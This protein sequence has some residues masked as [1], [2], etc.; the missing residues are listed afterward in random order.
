VSVWGFDA[1]GARAVGLLAACRLLPGAIAL[2]FGAWAADR[3]P[4]RRVAV[5]VFS[6]EAAALLGVAAAMMVDAPVGIVAVIVGS[7]SVALTPYRPAHLA[8]IP[9]AAR[10][11]EQLVAANVAS[12]AIEGVAT[13]TGPLLAALLLLAADPWVPTLAA[14]GAA[15]LGVLAVSG[16]HVISDPSRAM[17]QQRVGALDA[18]AR[19]FQVLWRDRDQALIVGCFVMQLLVRGLLSVMI[20]LVAL[21][22]FELGDSGVGWLSAAVGAGAVIGAAVAVGLT[23]RRRLATPMAAGLVLW[24][25]PIAL[26]GVIPK[27]AVAAAALVVVGLGNSVLDVAGFSLLQ[28]MSDDISLGRVFGAF[29][30]VGVAISAGGA[31]LAPALVEWFGLRPALVVT[32]TVL[33]LTAALALHRL[34]QIDRTSE[35]P[36]ESLDVLI[37]L[38]LFHD[39][40]PTTLEKLASRCQMQVADAGTVVVQQGAQPDH[41]YILVDAHA[42]VV[43]DDVVVN[44]LGPGNHFGEIAVVGG[45]VRTA[46]VRIVQAGRLL[47]IAGRDFTD[48]V[49]G[50]PMTFALTSAIIRRR[51]TSDSTRVD[52]GSRHA[53]ADDADEAADRALLVDGDHPPA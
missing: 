3:Y 35:P 4:R 19:G 29:F 1:G 45:G 50:N 2:P 8:L 17:R 10:S 5:I 49:I 20:V 48:A 33:P 31:A 30:T 6:T 36:G 12:G 39:L 41:V 14:A 23:G 53:P 15:G 24:G 34:R 32:G 38:P 28:R 22:L 9:L 18:V 11:P 46:T 27:P 52:A 43:A 47:S 7:S 16:L 51:L 37:G 21:D 25:A 44:T 26:I 40:P 42:E 13:L